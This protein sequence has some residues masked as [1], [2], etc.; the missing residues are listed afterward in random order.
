MEYT[1]PL[2]DL[3]YELMRRWGTRARFDRIVG[4]HC[5]ICSYNSTLEAVFLDVDAG[6]LTKACVSAFWKL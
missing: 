5:T 1:W 2:S 6:I 3:S 4:C